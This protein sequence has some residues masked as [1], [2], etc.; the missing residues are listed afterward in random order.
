MKAKPLAPISYEP[1][2][3]GC[4]RMHRLDECDTED[5]AVII[6]ADGKVMTA[7]KVRDRA[8]AKAGGR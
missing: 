8:R 2:C 4:G 3:G 5:A 6:E 7:V 1:P